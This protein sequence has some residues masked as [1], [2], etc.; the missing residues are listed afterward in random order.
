MFFCAR[1]Q[2]RKSILCWKSQ[3]SK[4]T[5]LRIVIALI[6][7]H[8]VYS[9]RQLLSIQPSGT[10]ATNGCKLFT[11]EPQVK[12]RNTKKA[13]TKSRREIASNSR[14]PSALQADVDCWTNTDRSTH[15]AI[16]DR[17]VGR[18]F[19]AGRYHVEWSHLLLYT[20]DPGI[21]RVRARHGFCEKWD[22]GLAFGIFVGHTLSFLQIPSGAIDYI[23]PYNFSD[24]RKS[25][26]GSELT[27]LQFCEKWPTFALP[28]FAH[29]FSGTSGQVE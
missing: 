28:S 27:K 9:Y 15:T 26:I 10:N 19:F 18:R 29:F 21:I 14:L 7:L 25:E 5:Y 23:G 24:A 4:H 12:G 20:W 22:L 16:A 13:G 17:G 11:E 6:C 2:R 3:C 8:G 1:T